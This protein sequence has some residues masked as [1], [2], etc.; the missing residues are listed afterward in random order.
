MH[1]L[2]S[3]Q[4]VFVV[5]DCLLA[6]RLSDVH[7]KEILRMGRVKGTVLLTRPESLKLT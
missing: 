7:L 5:T 3:A 2:F 1:K 4:Q 6:A